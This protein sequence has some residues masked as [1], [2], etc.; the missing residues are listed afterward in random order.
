[1]DLLIALSGLV[2]LVYYARPGGPRPVVTLVVFTVAE[3]EAVGIALRTLGAT[4]LVIVQRVGPAALLLSALKCVGAYALV[5]VIAFVWRRAHPPRRHAVAATALFLAASAVFYLWD[6]EKASPK[7]FHG[8]FV[9][10]GSFVETWATRPHV[11]YRVNTLGFRGAE[12]T[13]EKP[14]GTFRVVVVGDSFVFGSGVEEQDTVSE[15]L[16]ADLVRRWPTRPVEVLN[17]GIAGANLGTHARMVQIARDVFAPDAI[18]LC[19]TLGDDLKRS[20][21]Q[22]DKQALRRVSLFSFASFWLSSTPVV[23]LQAQI[24]RQDWADGLRFL[25][26]TM[27]SLAKAPGPH[28]PIFVYGGAGDPDDSVWDQ[29]RRLPEAVPVPVGPTSPEYFIPGDGHPTAVANAAYAARLGAAIA[30]D[31][32]LTAVSDGAPQ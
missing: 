14:A 1:M 7:A 9:P 27:A 21:L 11:A 23:A 32:R 28:P 17:L 25:G 18:V 2:W 29:V 31:V 15:R 3:F 20:D 8:I 10:Q 6:I 22:D 13:P 30:S 5:V 19:L 16:R 24:Y 12:W 4:I 26:E